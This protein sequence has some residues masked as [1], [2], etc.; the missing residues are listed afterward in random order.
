M[1]KDHKDTIRRN[2]VKLSEETPFPQILNHLYQEKVFSKTVVEDILWEKPT[3]RNW[4]FLD[5][6]QR[7]G[8]TA[9]SKFILALKDCGKEDLA[10][11][12]EYGDSP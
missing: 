6:I 4:A 10:K 5:A 1:E 2:W 12:L 8:P 11:L 7:S 3:Q 9:Y